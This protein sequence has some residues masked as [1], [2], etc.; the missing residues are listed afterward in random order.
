M[1]DDKVFSQRNRTAPDLWRYDLP[2]HVRARI[3]YTFEHALRSKL[4]VPNIFGAVL[5]DITKKCLRLYG[6]LSAQP[7]DVGEDYKCPIIEHFH[8]CS[9]DQAIDFIEMMFRSGEVPRFGPALVE[10]INDILKEEG[11]GF[12]FSQYVK[13]DGQKYVPARQIRYARFPEAI[14]KSNEAMHQAVVMPCLELMNGARWDAAN[15]H[16]RKAHEH[17]R[18]GNFR[19]AITE[20]QSAFE[21]VLKTIC[22]AKG[23]AYRENQDT[24]SQLIDVCKENGLFF[25]LYASIL[26]S[27]ASIRNR[28]GAH[29]TEPDPVLVPTYEHADH[30]INAT[31]A[32]I[33]FVAKSAKLEASVQK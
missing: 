20:C 21:T 12:A 31:S 1:S 27:S 14:K 25:P 16:L 15:Q 7:S 30:M 10:P 8:Y 6:S 23:W 2:I 11:I 22:K 13:A 24:V 33:L 26:T 32:N 17:H 28:L 4:F 29:G 18:H 3:I 19:E 5:D 9:T